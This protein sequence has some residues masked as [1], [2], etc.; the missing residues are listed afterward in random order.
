VFATTIRPDVDNTFY[1]TNLL[2]GGVVGTAN[3]RPIPLTP[4]TIS[5]RVVTSKGT[6]E[7][8]EDDIRLFDD[9]SV[10][11]PVLLRSVN[12][13][14]ATKNGGRYAQLT[15]T[16]FRGEFTFSNVPSG[17][18]M[19][20]VFNPRK[21]NR[22]TSNYE[23][24][25]PKESNL[26]ANYAGPKTNVGRRVIPDARRPEPVVAPVGNRY[27]LNDPDPVKFPRSDTGPTVGSADS[28]KP[29]D[30]GV[31][32][33]VPEGASVSG[34]VTLNGTPY[35]GAR[36][37]LSLVNAD[38]TLTVKRSETTPNTGIY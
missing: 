38:G 27:V 28:D 32:I 24:D 33:V 37:E 21:D 3:L 13:T 16:N 15:K 4:G 5:G 8:F 34:V 2:E 17:V 11:M 7:N 20:V 29:A 35:G 6:P 1:V 26:D 25:T 19:E 23:G 36:V 10:D 18:P 30:S 14:S 9:K 31:P 12:D 22:N